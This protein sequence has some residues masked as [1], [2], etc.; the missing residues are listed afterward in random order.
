[1]NNYSKQILQ[2]LKVIDL[3]T[4][5]AGP[6]VGTFLAELGATVTKIEHPE[7]GDVTRTWKL[8]TESKSAS[9]SAYFSSVNFQKE[10][11]K[12]NLNKE[13]DRSNLLEELKNAD[14]LLS[15]FK[16]GD[17]EKF[18]LTDSILTAFNPRLI[19]GKITGFGDES[20][21]VA[22]D[23]VLQAETGFMSMN[24]TPESG[25]VKMPV[26]LIDVL[27]AHHLKEAI[28]L[29]LFHRERTGKGAV[30]SV[31]LYD[32]AVASLANQASNYLMERKIPQRIGSLHPNIA[33]YGELFQTLD[34]ATITFA[35]GSDKHFQLLLK[36]L[37]LNDVGSND[38]FVSNQSR[39]VNRNA[40]AEI[41]QER[42]SK[43]EADQLL[44]ALH[45]LHVPCA[46][47]R[48]LAE[49]FEDVKAKDLVR[50]ESIDGVETQRV[51]SIVFKWK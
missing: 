22:Y 27:A 39:V 41:L 30:L 3:S 46:K 21:R 14:V 47:V 38:K 7:F 15:N 9:V 35:I 25:P 24:G 5:L 45:Q 8:P 2:G 36:V 40:L 12:L 42:I 48:D 19:I 44:N 1:M 6:S 31:S 29:A 51:T 49:V 17:A 26:A 50:R 4:V 28:L 32:A 34:G 18:Q 37:D 43:M 33:P 10:Y 16:L 13:E 23:L 20:D 11:K